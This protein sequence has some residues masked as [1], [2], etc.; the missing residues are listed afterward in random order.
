VAI[1][2]QTGL[3]ARYRVK[4]RDVLAPRAFCPEILQDTPDPWA[5]GQT[6]WDAV[7]GKFQLADAEENARFSGL[8]EDV[9]PSPVRV[10][11]EGD[12][13]TVV[14]AVLVFRHSFICQRYLIPKHGSELGIETRVCWNEKDSMLK[15]NLPFSASVQEF[16]GQTA[17]GTQPF[18]IDGTESC[19]QQWVA[20]SLTGDTVVTCINDGIYASDCRERELRLTLLRSPSYAGM[21]FGNNPLIVQS[22]RFSPRQEQGEHVFRFWL[23]TGPAAERLPAVDL[24]AQLKHEPPFV[25]PFSPAGSGSPLPPAIRFGN[26]G[27]RLAAMKRAE[28][29]DDLIL[30]VFNPSEAPV[31]SDVTIPPR[32]VSGHIE[33][34]PFE[35]QTLRLSRE[36]ST[37]LRVNLLED[38]L[39]GDA[40]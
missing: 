22:D 38:R 28:D 14:E 37:V 40:R 25:M 13:R 20:V 6:R 39:E 2:T 21:P 1:D 15:L 8:S 18:R 9:A 12:I 5:F 26:P 11:E 4:G 29:N 33:L 23:N 35:I 10:I 17:Y 7:I 19:A 24:E 31:E 36:R 32:G 3:I 16:C 34:G 30:R 27:V